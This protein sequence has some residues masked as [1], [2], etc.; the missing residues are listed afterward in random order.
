MI[1]ELGGNILEVTHQRMFASL[2][3]READ[4]YITVETRDAEQ[5]EEILQQLQVKG[6]LAELVQ[7]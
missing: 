4:L 1:G 3:V 7:E 5:A 2:P 6:Y